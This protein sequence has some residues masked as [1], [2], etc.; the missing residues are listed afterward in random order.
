MTYCSEVTDDNVAGPLG[1]LEEDGHGAS[2]T[3][4]L[5]G[6]NR[7][8][9]DRIT[10]DYKS[11]PPYSTTFEQVSVFTPLMRSILNLGQVLATSAT[12]TIRCMNCRSE[13][14]KPGTTFVNDLIYPLPVSFILA[15]Q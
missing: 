10:Q 3:A 5:Q 2:L 11:I 12:T 15:E 14:T 9:L 1:L 8:L 13:H 7:F 6:L 4:M